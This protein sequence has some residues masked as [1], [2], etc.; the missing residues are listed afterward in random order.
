MTVKPKI[1]FLD[2]ETAPMLGYVWSLWDQNVALNQ[3][4]KDWSILSW[5]AKWAD[6]EY[7]Y[8]HDVRDNTDINNDANILR[9]IYKLLE[10]A[11]ILVTHNG[12]KFDIPKL[13]A[14]FI[15]NGFRPLPLKSHIDTL[16][17]ARKHFKFS[18][19]KL[20]YLARIL[21]PKNF[22]K[23]TKRKFSGFELW[24]ECLRGNE[25]AWKEMEAY[26]CQ[27]VLVLEAVYE[28]LR[29]WDTS[30]NFSVFTDSN[31]MVC[32][33]GSTDFHRRG[34]KYT[35]TGKY[36]MYSCITCGSHRRGAENLL[37]KKKRKR[38]GRNV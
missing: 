22:Q 19:N 26:N 38:M 14:R 15:Q 2:I 16:Q 21:L 5:S 37:G 34:Y 9:T 29:P 10:K 24:S 7:I 4:H 1:L 35:A 11:D 25:K 18:S 32:S 12:K 30:V 17:I 27:D 33:C 36:Q 8:Y 3:I 31:S 13:N 20:E 23:L 28:K 6:E